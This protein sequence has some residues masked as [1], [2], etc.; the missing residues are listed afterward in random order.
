MGNIFRKRK[1]K[2]SKRSDTDTDLLKTGKTRY[3]KDISSY[4]SFTSVLGTIQTMCLSA[5]G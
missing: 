1:P 3:E 5:Y 2:E 4:L